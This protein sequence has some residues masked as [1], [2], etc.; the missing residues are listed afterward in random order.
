MS[1]S[2]SS[3]SP[4]QSPLKFSSPDK[5]S[6]LKSS[7]GPQEYQFN[8]LPIS[9]KI[10]NSVIIPH[11]PEEIVSLFNKKEV[12]ISKLL[13]D[14]KNLSAFIH[15]NVC[16]ITNPLLL[17]Y[18]KGSNQAPSRQREARAGISLQGSRDPE[19]PSDPGALP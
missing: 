7:P 4:N 12:L 10:I 16:Y 15:H 19:A 2:V 9:L 11:S 3:Y 8:S 6:N 14:N 13:E 18:N 5:I 17:L 1:L